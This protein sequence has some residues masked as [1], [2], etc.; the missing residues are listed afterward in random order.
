MQKIAR[1]THGVN[2]KDEIFVLSTLRTDA[3]PTAR[4]VE[5]G[6]ALFR[7]CEISWAHSTLLAAPSNVDLEKPWVAHRLAKAGVDQRDLAGA[8]EF[9]HVL[10]STLSGIST[11]VWAAHVLD[12]DLAGLAL[13]RTVAEEKLGSLAD[14]VP[15]PPIRINISHLAAIM[16]PLLSRSLHEMGR[17]YSVRLGRTTMERTVA[18]GRVLCKMLDRLPDDPDRLLTML[19][20]A[21]AEYHRPRGRTSIDPIIAGRVRRGRT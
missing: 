15:C 4:V 20:Q 14:L 6:F 7:K 21:R 11:P 3:G 12:A 1:G 2:W 18:A 8:P 13:E 19:R 9:A 10:K 5:I 16:H 17:R